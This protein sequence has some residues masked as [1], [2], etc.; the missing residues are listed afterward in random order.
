MSHIYNE[1]TKLISNERGKGYTTEMM[2]AAAKF[3]LTSKGEYVVFVGADRNHV[4]NM[5][6]MA[7]QMFSQVLCHKFS[8]ITFQQ[9]QTISENLKD[10]RYFVDHYCYVKPLLDAAKGMSTYE[11]Q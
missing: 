1:I 9:Y 5:K 11:P 3:L 7:G 10:G 4:L 8:F 2:F 6:Q